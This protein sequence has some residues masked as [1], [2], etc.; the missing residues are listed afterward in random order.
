MSRKLCQLSYGSAERIFYVL[1]LFSVKTKFAQNP[2]LFLARCMDE[3][4]NFDKINGQ[5]VYS[6]KF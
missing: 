5:I 2:F 6:I 3:N 1:F 4:L